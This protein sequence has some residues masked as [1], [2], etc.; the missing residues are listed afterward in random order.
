MAGRKRKRN[1]AIGAVGGLVAL[2]ATTGVGAQVITSTGGSAAGVAKVSGFFPAI[3]TAVG[4]GLVL[5]EVDK[6]RK[7]VRRK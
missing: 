7:V 1:N 2:G 6:L 3:G 5:R 4:A